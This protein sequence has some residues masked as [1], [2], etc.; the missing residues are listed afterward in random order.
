MR[1]YKTK[2]SGSVHYVTLLPFPDGSYK[3]RRCLICEK[4]DEVAQTYIVRLHRLNNTLSELDMSVS[5]F[6]QDI[7]DFEHDYEELT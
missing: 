1:V 5:D 6:Y 2:C 7:E 3:A 4:R